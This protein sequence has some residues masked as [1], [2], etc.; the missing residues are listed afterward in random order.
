MQVYH[1]PFPLFLINA[2][3]AIGGVESKLTQEILL[4]N[5]LSLVQCHNHDLKTKE[6]D[7]LCHV[8]TS[9]N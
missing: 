1:F 2:G 8:I 7:R 9:L 4:Q 5:T 3:V 6:V